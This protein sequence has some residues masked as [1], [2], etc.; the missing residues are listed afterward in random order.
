MNMRLKANMMLMGAGIPIVATPQKTCAT[1]KTTIADR[2]S[3]DRMVRK[4]RDRGERGMHWYVCPSCKGI[5]LGHK[6]RS[7]KRRIK[8]MCWD[9]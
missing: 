8:S 6:Q 5:H 4:M 3:A 2:R 7:K 1:G 9:D